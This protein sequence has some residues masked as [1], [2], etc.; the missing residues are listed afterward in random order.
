MLS[1]YGDNHSFGNCSEVITLNNQ[2]AT[3]LSCG[4][5]A[6]AIS[7]FCQALNKSKSCMFDPRE[8]RSDEQET[9]PTSCF[10][11]DHL[12]EADCFGLHCEDENDESCPSHDRSNSAI[13]GSFTFP[14]ENPSRQ[15]TNNL[16]N[17]EKLINSGF[18]YRKCIR[19]P[20][21]YAY[22]PGFQRSQVLLTSIVIFNLALAH[23]IW[24]TQQQEVQEPES[25]FDSTPRVSMLKKAVKLYE[26]AIQ[27][28]EDHA[29]TGEPE[30]Y[31]K[32]FFLSCINNLGNTFRLLGDTASSEKIFQHLLTV[33]MYLNYNEQHHGFDLSTA[34]NT[35]D[36]D[37]SSSSATQN[38]S[39]T[40]FSAGK[41]Y[42]S[43]FRNIFESDIKSAPAA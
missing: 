13:S 26:L 38:S 35:M 31:S 5:M 2:G 30:S 19:V 36:P 43:F 25:M 3:A 1:V 16:T 29:A 27:L 39:T 41:T 18:I 23:H 22:N 14:S 20:S 24:A 12:M 11:V 4:Y 9:A 17:D 28:Q 21:S 32:L 7:S 6:S 8:D 15:K 33:L 40:F 10:D 42:R 37:V 34:S